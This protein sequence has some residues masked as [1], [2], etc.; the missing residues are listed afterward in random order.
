MARAQYGSCYPAE[1]I[2]SIKLCGLPLAGKANQRAS[3]A[4]SH[5]SLTGSLA[6]QMQSIKESTQGI[7][8]A[9][10]E[11]KS[12]VMPKIENST[13]LKH[14]KPM[15]EA[16]NKAGRNWNWDAQAALIVKFILEESGNPEMLED[17]FK[18]DRKA[19]VAEVLKFGYPKNFQNSYL[20][21]TL[22]DDGKPL[23]AAVVGKDE[24]AAN[25]FI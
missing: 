6:S 22:D 24:V 3:L 13:V 5:P 23:M 15:C 11:S 19:L 2:Q 21:K 12:K 25:E 8:L 16:L 7:T 1:I 9:E 18:E 14:A 17:G 10:Y 20:S 4:H